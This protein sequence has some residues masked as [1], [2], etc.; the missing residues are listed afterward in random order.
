[1]AMWKVTPKHWYSW[2]FAVTDDLGQDVGEVRVS[3][4]WNRGTV[5]AGCVEH[6]VSRDRLLGGAFVLRGAD[7][8][9]ARAVGRS[10]YRITIVIVWEEKRYFLHARSTLRREFGFWD[11]EKEVGSVVPVRAFSRA[12]RAELPDDLP[13]VVRLFAVWLAEMFWKRGYQSHW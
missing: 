8:P 11:G 7:A 6:K 1:M 2:E 12:A 3:S 4:W 9:I 10:A 5:V 13:L